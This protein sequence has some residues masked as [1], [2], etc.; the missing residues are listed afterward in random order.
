MRAPRSARAVAALAGLWVAALPLV[1]VAAGTSITVTPS[2]GLGE[3]QQVRVQAAGFT[4]GRSLV[5]TECQAVAQTTQN[6][7]DLTHAVFV[8]ADAQ[9]RVDTPFTVHRGPFGL[10]AVR[11]DAPPG[12]KVSVTDVSLSPTEVATAPIGFAPATATGPAAT[13]NTPAGG[14]PPSVAAS[15]LLAVPIVLAA[16]WAA[17][18]L[19]LLGLRRPLA[20]IAAGMLLIGAAC[21]QVNTVVTASG[22][23]AGVNGATIYAAWEIVDDVVAVALLATA[24]LRLGR[25]APS[26]ARAVAV[27]E[28]LLVPAALLVLLPAVTVL[29]GAATAEGGGWIWY[30][31][32]AAAVAAAAVAITDLAL[33]PARR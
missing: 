15:W 7:C 8:S 1:A 31:A 14:S 10:A 30:G 23:Q 13:G 25:P 28:V 32:S 12:C 20:L 16:L 19:R 17:L 18:L 26:A 5:V 24:A 11:C 9:G 6:D 27:L 3:A 22:T 21:V 29:G 33:G 4:P 2:Q